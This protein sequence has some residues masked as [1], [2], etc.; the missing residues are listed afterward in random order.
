[1]TSTK[2]AS[3]KL[4]VFISYSRDD[5][6]FAD[7]LIAALALSDCATTIDRQGI[8][9]GEDW[10]RRLGNLI[11]DADTV[12]FV[13]S[14]SSARSPICAW[15][16]EEAVRMGKRIIPVLC[17]PLDDVQPSPHLTDLNYIYFYTDPKVPG[18]G[19]GTGQVRLV[20]ALDTDLDWLREHTRLL[21]R[22][23]EWQSSRKPTSRLL[24]GDSVAEAVLWIANKPRNAPEPTA[25]QFEF[26]RASEEH[27]AQR[28]NAENRHREEIALLE[29][30]RAKA[31]KEREAERR[32]SAIHVRRMGMLMTFGFF[33]AVLFATLAGSLGFIVLQKKREIEAQRQLVLKQQAGE[34]AGIAAFP[35]DEGKVGGGD[36]SGANPLDIGWTRGKSSG[37]DASKKSM[38]LE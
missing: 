15:E 4:N 32:K 34:S 21:Q 29:A 18:S 9:G 13:L 7:Q 24:F 3:G 30:A 6:V 33:A 19:F 25:L 37:D 22:A 35:D 12:V 2:T 38:Q 31:H 17:R 14:P 23:T 8:F 1:M 10:K 5:I 27:E 11:R 36:G 26:I 20:A 28:V 16:A